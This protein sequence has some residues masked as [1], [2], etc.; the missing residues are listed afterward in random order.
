MKTLH[1]CNT[2]V[3]LYVLLHGSIGVN[4]ILDLVS[5][6]LKLVLDGFEVEDV[7]VLGEPL[8]LEVEEALSNLWG[9][10]VGLRVNF[11]RGSSLLVLL[12][13]L[14]LLFGRVSR[15]LSFLVLH[16]SILSGWGLPCS[17]TSGCTAVS[18]GSL[19]W[20]WSIL[21]DGD[22]LLF[23]PLLLNLRRLKHGDLVNAVAHT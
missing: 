16:L 19:S 11:E 14:K 23:D 20:L 18:L 2:G 9:K 10:S 8:L 3:L 6:R 13:D 12:A 22:L 4:V 1:K 15:L 21:L 17:I 5:E 7:D